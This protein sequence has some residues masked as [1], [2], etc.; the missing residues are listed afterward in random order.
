MGNEQYNSFDIAPAMAE[1]A[2]Q[3]DPTR[4]IIDSDGCS[5]KHANRES[6]D[7]LVVQ[8][9]EGNS[10]GHQDR[11]YEIP[12]AIAKPVIAHEMGYFVTLPDLAQVD[13]FK[14]GLRPYWL[15][16]TRDLAKEN[17]WLGAYPE[18]LA[19]SHRLQAACLKTN[20]EA[21]RRSRLSGTSVWLFHDYPN[22]AEGV[23]GMF[24][25][26]KG[27]SAA[28]FRK[29]NAPTVLLLDAPRRNWWSGETVKLT[30]VVSRFEDAPSRDATLRWRLHNGDEVIAQ[31]EQSHL[32]IR[33]GE[34][35]ELPTITLDLPSLV[36]ASKL[37]ISAELADAGVTT[38]NSWGVWMFP[39]ENHEGPSSQVRS[40]GFE[41]IRALFPNTVEHRDGPIP[42][43]TGLL[44][45]TRLD[46]DITRYLEGGGRVFLLDPEPS[47]AV[48]RTN[49][50]LSSW[51]GGGPSGT[52]VDLKHPAMS[53]FPSDGWC[54]L[55]FYPLIQ[56]SK[57]ILLN[58]LQTKFEPLIRCI[59]RP[60]R[61]ADRAYLFEASAGRG[62]LLVSG[63]N[64]GEA[65]KAGDP[66]ATFLFDRLVR[67]AL[68]SDFKPK[69]SLPVNVLRTKAAK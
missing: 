28:E 4:P 15:L 5:F 56:K 67:Y 68:G 13:R 23:V 3:L 21:A 29:F 12:P 30:F 57:T 17:G 37:T 49:F 62:K 26:P 45:S 32:A 19:A 7:Y 61:L 44:V 55:Q 1:A 6:L 53:D 27:I 46:D 39:R 20:L 2:R 25:Q 64:F 66:A 31:G 60:T 8:F 22:C 38:E 47:F 63:L 40:A 14:G 52:I 34:V 42:S 9:G 59:D 48:E 69:A 24:G 58:P 41:P 10:I 16:Q 51:D 36:R 43:D 11:K 33:S 65:L 50:R 54:D 35:Q 18:W